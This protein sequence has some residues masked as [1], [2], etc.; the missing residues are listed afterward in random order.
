MTTS[1]PLDP[2]SAAGAPPSPLREIWTSFSASRGALIAATF[3]VLLV[4]AAVF[5]PWIAPHA[6]ADQFRDFFLVPPAWTSGGASGR[7]LRR[8]M[9]T[10]GTLLRRVSAIAADDSPA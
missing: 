6:P 3:F 10:P 9:R 1:L 5:A 2:D 8:E 7:S 4:L